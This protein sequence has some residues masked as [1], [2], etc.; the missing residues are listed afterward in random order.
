[1]ALGLVGK[2]GREQIWVKVSSEMSKEAP[3]PP[4]TG[5]PTKSCQAYYTKSPQIHKLTGEEF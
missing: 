4:A 5:H 1:M 3:I 2:T